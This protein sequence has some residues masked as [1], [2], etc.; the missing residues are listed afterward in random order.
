MQH[1]PTIV[2]VFV[3]M[4]VILALIAAGFGV[5]YH[6]DTAP[7]DWQTPR[8]DTIAMQGEG[9]YRY[10]SVSGATQM[11]S[12]DLVTLIIG[13]PLLLI[14]LILYRR[15]SLRGHLLLTGTLGYF[16]YTYASIAFLAAFNPFFLIYVALFS[17]SLI[18]FI[19]I[20]AA[21]PIAELPRHFSETFPRRALAIFLFGIG[22][23]IGAMWLG[24]V[25]PPTLSGSYPAELGSYTTLVIQVLDLGVILPAAVLG[26]YYLLKRAPL[27]YLLAS[28]VCIKGLTLGT[29][30]SVM[31]IAMLRAGIEEASLGQVIGFVAI[32]LI[33]AGMTFLLLRSLSE[34]AAPAHA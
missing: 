33:G 21:L 34:T 3:L 8:G 10:D 22:L 11:I 25:V 30:V 13:V 19:V 14:S 27:G 17:T 20:I 12:G 16:L 26:G 5:F 7:F 18:S 9:L 2:T 1:R 31:G 29:A 24:M 4:I 23:F 15:G 28:V 32:T 6:N